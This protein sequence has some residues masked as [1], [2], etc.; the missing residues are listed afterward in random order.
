MSRVPRFSQSLALLLLFACQRDAVG[1]T[2]SSSG[3]GSLFSTSL[4]A[5]PL[6]LASSGHI[7]FTR[8]LP[9]SARWVFKMDATG[10]N[11]TQLAN[12]YA[13][14]WKPDG[15]KIAFSCGANICVMNN[16]GTGIVQLT[17]NVL[18][19][20]PAWSGSSLAFPNGRIAFDGQDPTG[21]WHIYVMNPDGTGVVQLTKDATIDGSAD[22]SPDGSKI[23]FQRY[24]KHG[25]S[26]V[27]VMNASPGS[28]ITQLTTLGGSSPAWSRDGTK[29]AFDSYRS[30]TSQ[31][32][33]MS[34]SGE[35]AGPAVQITTSGGSLSDWSLDGTRIVFRCPAAKATNI[36][37]INSDGT[38]GVVDL[39]NSRQTEQWPEWGP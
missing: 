2:P 17:F 28:V 34:S 1:P 21:N 8:I 30:G 38:G 26:Q 13:A 31:I 3:A 25:T 22:W 36:C 39:T 35:T 11:V 9:P 23:A 32:Y 33:V 37:T 19:E 29:I 4:P 16:D 18:V 10:A 27:F 12:G 14:V 15:S 20:V 7:L 5:S 24:V 6:L